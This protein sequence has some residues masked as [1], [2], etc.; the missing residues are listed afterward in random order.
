M[1][2]WPPAMMMSASPL[3]A[4]AAHLADCEGRR[5]VGQTSANDRLTRR[6]L[7][8]TGGQHLTQN[9]FIDHVRLDAG[10]GQQPLDYVRTKIRSGNLRQR[11]AKLANCC[12]QCCNDYDVIHV[13]SPIKTVKET[14]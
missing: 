8:T 5:H 10:F 11:S 13:D 4:A 9:H 14:R 1:F 3:Q 12:S 2:S 6:I 7:A